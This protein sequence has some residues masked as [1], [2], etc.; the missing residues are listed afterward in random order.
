MPATWAEETTRLGVSGSP[1]EPEIAIY[2]GASYQGRMVRGWSS[3]RPWLDRQQ[4]GQ[5]R[6]NAGFGNLLRAQRACGGPPGYA[7]IIACLPHITGDHSRETITYV[8]RI[9]RYYHML[10]VGL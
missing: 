7:A 1:F 5:A 2:V 8:E 4:L 10:A 3:P 9:E 6:Y